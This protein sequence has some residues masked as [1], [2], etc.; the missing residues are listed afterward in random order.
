MYNK[1]M[2]KGESANEHLWYI[3]KLR[4][5]VYYICWKAFYYSTKAKP[6][7]ACTLWIIE[8]GV[9]QKMSEQDTAEI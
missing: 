2:H 4:D 3:S 7:G 6:K 5:S 1:Y 9:K 8:Y